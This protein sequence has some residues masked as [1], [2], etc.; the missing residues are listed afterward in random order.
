MASFVYRA[1]SPAGEVA[2]GEADGATEAEVIDRSRDQGL[3]PMHVARAGHQILTGRPRTT[4]V[5]VKHTG[6]APA[7]AP[8][9]KAPTIQKPPGILA[10][11][12]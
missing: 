9:P 11:S 1:V 8:A 5:P 7:P 10:T 4:T 3:L 6:P 2:T 12:G